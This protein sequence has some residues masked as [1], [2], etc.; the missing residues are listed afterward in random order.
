MK[1]LHIYGSSS[2]IR[3]VGEVISPSIGLNY[4]PI[5]YPDVNYWLWM[6]NIFW[7]NCIYEIL[8]HDKT[9]M[10]NGDIKVPYFWFEP[11][12]TL[13]GCCSTATF[14]IDWAIKLGCER[15]Y[16]Y[17]IFDD[18]YIIEGDYV[19][20]QQFYKPKPIKFPLNKFKLVE[21]FIEECKEKIEIIQPFKKR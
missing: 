18:D 13:M 20:W 9:R 11:N 12:V 5:Y 4:F 21:Q 7:G 6:D 1:E 3:L 8:V 19:I 15:V 10:M 17:G 16:L 14:A 2:K